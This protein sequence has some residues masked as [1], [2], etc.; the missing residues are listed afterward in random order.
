MTNVYLE[1][2]GPVRDPDLSE[3]DY[4]TIERADGRSVWRQRLLVSQKI[5]RIYILTP[6]SDTHGYFYA[7][8]KMLSGPSPNSGKHPVDERSTPQQVIS[9]LPALPKPDPAIKIPG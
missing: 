4:L 8:P 3:G 1:I 6:V 5:G 9:G 7:Q 2:D